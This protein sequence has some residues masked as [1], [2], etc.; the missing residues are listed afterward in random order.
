MRNRTESSMILE[1][2]LSYLIFNLRDKKEGSMINLFTLV[3]DCMSS[4][5]IN[6]SGDG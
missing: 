1:M 2:S 6:A 4:S 3:V 5:I